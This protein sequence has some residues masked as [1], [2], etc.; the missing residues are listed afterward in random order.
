MAG[1]AQFDLLILGL[2]FGAGVEARW[3][4]ETRPSTVIDMNRLLVTVWEQDLAA[5]GTAEVTV[6]NS[7]LQ[8]SV[9]A[10]F[11][12]QI[13][14]APN[15]S[16]RIN[17]GGVVNA[18]TF[19]ATRLAPGVIASVFG[20]DLAPETEALIAT[21]LTTTLGGMT[22]LFNGNLKAPLYYASPNQVNMLVPWE[23][24]GEEQA[25]FSVR[26]GSETSQPRC[27]PS[28]SI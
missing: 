4:G 5:E 15:L 6:V 9:P 24:A 25:Q 16:P 11:D 17:P 2:N 7:R 10:R 27:R 28:G 22:L 12:F 20:L 14:P 18:A 13:N 8:G 1:G 19:A 26:I 23:L 3:K 21:P